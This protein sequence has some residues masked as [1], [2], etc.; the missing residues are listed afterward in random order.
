MIYFCSDLDNTLIYSYRHDIGSNKVLVETKEGKELSY[1]SEVSHKLLQEVA[2]VKNLVP[3]TTRSIEQYS[4]ISF[5]SQVKIQYA[6]VANGGILLEDN[7]INE[8]WRRETKEIISYA[9]EEMEKGIEIL[10]KDENVCFEV[11]KVDGLSV[12]TK[13]SN[14][15][16]T[17][18]RLKENLDTDT[19]YIDSNGMKV[20]IFPKALDKGSSL[21]RFRKYVGENNYFIAAGDSGFDVPMLLA[22]DTAFCPESLEVSDK[23]NIVKL[24]EHRFSEEMLL[25]VMNM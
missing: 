9:E 12:F 18:G 13:S 4:R 14:V 20:Y 16:V 10:K 11:R 25:R 8:E 15:E 17:I 21:K 22:A 1:M 23:E 5:G 2:K 6:L 7:K 19:V 3:L 24:A